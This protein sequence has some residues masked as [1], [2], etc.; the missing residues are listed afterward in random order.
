MARIVLVGAGHCHVEVLRQAQRIQAAG[1]SLTLIT[2]EETHTYS[3]MAPGLISGSWSEE[4]A[5]LPVA[6]LA[7]A[8]GVT[9]VL[10]H[11]VQR[12]REGKTIITAR[13]KAVPYDVL[14][15]NIGS[16]TVMTP[17]STD[18]G[19]IPRTT[20][21]VKPVH[22]L[23]SLREAI[24]AHA[25]NQVQVAVIGGG[26]GGIEVAANVASLVRSQRFSGGTVTLYAHTLARDLPAR[27]LRRKYVLRLLKKLDIRIIDG[28]RVDP[29]AVPGD[30][31]VI[32]TGIA[33]PPVL[34]AMG[35]PV[36]NDGAVPVDRFLRVSG[37][38]GV[39]AVGDCAAFQTQPLRRV[40][41]YAVRQQKIL[42][43]NLI[44]YADSPGSARLSPFTAT[45][46]FLQG[47]N[48]GPR[49]GLLF[50]GPVT[51][52]GPVAWYLKRAI[53]RRFL[54]KY[55]DSLPPR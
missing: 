1:H 15:L 27:S 8:F 53:D 3:G 38:D 10:D 23:S 30:I 32:A 51:L 37:E 33:P 29:Q 7:R 36:V 17:G 28:E 43:S 24:L 48:L 2:P 44:A 13:G 40:G 19:G 47:M 6:Q 25:E 42:V 22:N 52:T 12:D 14:S 5:S 55:R 39:F 49:R 34:K 20:W 16:E 46:P 54:K 18:H 35:F 9:L 50:R 41:V 4:D 21:G 11:A 31:V 45:G 26:F